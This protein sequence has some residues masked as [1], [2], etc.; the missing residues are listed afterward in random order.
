MRWDHEFSKTVYFS[1][2]LRATQ[3][4]GAL[5]CDSVSNIGRFH[6][7]IVFTTRKSMDVI[8]TVWCILFWYNLGSGL[9][10]INIYLNADTLM[11]SRGWGLV[12][13]YCRRMF[14]LEKVIYF[15]VWLDITKMYMIQ[16]KIFSMKKP[17]SPSRW[18]LHEEKSKHI[19]RAYSPIEKGIIF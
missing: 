16:R 11:S 7:M 3:H 15:V 18:S 2:I 17:I 19:D 8:L 1:H 13:I 14:T 5:R 9:R 6:I 12:F 4:S 10:S